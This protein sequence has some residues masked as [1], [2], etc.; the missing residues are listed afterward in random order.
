MATQ[1]ELERKAVIEEANKWM[2]TPFRHDAEVVGAGVDC[3]H[4]INAV[5][6][7]VGKMPNVVFPQYPPDW[8]KHTDDPEQHIIENAKKYFREITA[9]EAKPGDWVVLY[10][11]KAWAHCAILVGAHKVIEA[12]PLRSLVSLVN[13]REESLYRN[14]QKRYF[15]S[16]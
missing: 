16:W 14:H 12:W 1:E 2:G 5:Y 7:A 6:F 9:E 8:F 10:I 13:V 3:A 11:G 15:T 4:L